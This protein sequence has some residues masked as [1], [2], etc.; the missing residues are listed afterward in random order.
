LHFSILL[1]TLAVGLINFGD[2]VGRISGLILTATAMGAMF[3]SVHQFLTRA[4]N[5][6]KRVEGPYDDRVGP[7]FA[8]ANRWGRPVRHTLGAVKV[9]SDVSR[10]RTHSIIPISHVRRFTQ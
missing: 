7:S 1:A 6:R 5:I 4:R 9:H 3:Y 2:R 8:D 10:H